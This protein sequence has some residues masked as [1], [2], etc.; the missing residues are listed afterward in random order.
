[1]DLELLRKDIS[2]K[3]KKG[4]P[5]IMTSVIIR[6]LI[7]IVQVTDLPIFTKNIL[8]FCASCPLMPLARFFGKKMGVDIFSKENPLG[9]LGFIFTLNQLLYL[10]IVFWI[11]NVLPE[12]MVMVYAMVFGAHL[13]PYSW[14]YKS[15]A[16]GIFALLIP[17][18]S[19]IIGNIFGSLALA[20]CLVIIEIIF[21]IFLFKELKLLD[22]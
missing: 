17:I 9:Q 4:L 20:F 22:K 12:K 15:T 13:L 8:V 18:V 14:L 11:F 1:M 6:G 5:F 3:Q 16:Y 2:I 21:V 7:S 19:L 10:F